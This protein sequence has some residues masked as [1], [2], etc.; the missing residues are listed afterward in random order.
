VASITAERRHLTYESARARIL[1][2]V[3][4]LPPAIL[5]LS[6]ARGRALRQ[7]LTAPHELPSFP[8]SS[9]DGYAVRVADLAS[10]STESPIDLPVL[11]VQPAGHVT[12]RPLEPGVVFRI[13]TGAQIPE[14]ADA[15]VPFE[16]TRRLEG[17]GATERVRFSHTPRTRENIRRAGEDIAAGEIA[18]EE[19]RELTPYDLAL[20]AALGIAHLAVGPAPKVAI[21]STGDELLAV[22]ETLRPGT[23]RDSNIPLLAALLAE[24]GCAVFRSKRVGDDSAQVLAS[25]RDALEGADVVIT[26]GGISMGDFDPV[27]QSVSALGEVEW[28]RIAMK[29]GQSQAFGTPRGRLFFALPGNPASVACVFET[30]VRPALRKL[31]GFRVLNR[32][33]LEVCVAEPMESRSG[34]TDF[35]RA[36]LERRSDVWWATAAGPQVSGHLTPQSRAHALVVI[37]ENAPAL[38]VGDRT[39]ALLL[40]WPED[41]S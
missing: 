17:P 29:P 6:E 20:L 4:T 14:G 41:G 16:Q 27:K 21:I 2:A 38:A 18:L 8:N 9:M 26:I 24:A 32:P 33:Q 12:S 36:K 35:V 5:P 31:Q 37:P 40:R 19:G 34:R 11:D 7:T 3:R 39:H 1:D 30:L 10:A 13:M 22:E 15:V 28:W 25:V 23:L